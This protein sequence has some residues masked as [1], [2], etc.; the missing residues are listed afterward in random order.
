MKVSFVSKYLL[1]SSWLIGCGT[2]PPSNFVTE[3]KGIY[4]D[5]IIDDS[6]TL[7]D[8][9]GDEEVELAV[10]DFLQANHLDGSGSSSTPDE[11]NDDSSHDEGESSG[12]ANVGSS[13]ALPANTPDGGSTPDDGT[14]SNSG[15]SSD[16]D[17]SESD[18]DAGTGEGSNNTDTDDGD[19][20]SDEDGAQQGNSSSKPTGNSAWGNARCAQI[21]KTDESSV[22]VID[23]GLGSSQQRISSTDVVMVKL[24]GN[25]S[26]YV[27]S[28]KG[29]SSSLK[30][31][32]LFV[33]GN[34]SQATISIE[35]ASVGAIVYIGRGN[36]SRGQVTIDDGD[37]G[38][39]GQLVVDL[40]GNQ[41][42]FTL[43]SDGG[44][45]CGSAYLRIKPRSH[46]SCF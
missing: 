22:R 8:L 6:Q 20:G 1:A 38:D 16:D 28:L 25:K 9:M 45:D 41:S 26:E 23:G 43:D 15:G 21:F 5:M 14:S 4:L 35:G 3:D 10:E 11:P 29:S 40:S 19:G 46:Y 7:E 13:D 32:C 34:Q 12:D 39:V 33:T 36:Q 31:I 44:F 27:L 2:P 42:S 30:G 17:S 37:D 18:D 24:T